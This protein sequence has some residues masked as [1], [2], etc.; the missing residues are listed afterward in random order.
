MWRY[1]A[2]RTGQTFSPAERF[3]TGIRNA[4][5]I[6]ADPTGL[7]I[8]ATQHGRDQLYE[9]WPDLYNQEQGANLP[10]EELLGLEEGADY[11]WPECYFDDT[12]NK[13]VLAPEYGGDGGKKVGVC[14]NKKPPIAVFPAHW[15]PNA[16]L[17]YYGDRFPAA[18]RGGGFIAFHGSWNR[19]PLPQGGYNVVFQPLA[20][21]KPSGAYVI[22]ADG[23]AGAVKEPGEAA[24]RPSGLALGSDGSLYI[25]DDQRGRIWKV[26][27]QGDRE[28]A[29]LAAAASPPAASAAT[30][31]EPPEGIH[32]GAGAE[33]T[34]ALPTPPGATPAQVALGDR[35]FHGQAGG[36]TCAGCHG[37]NAKGTPVGPDL[38]SGRRLW[39]DGSLPSI[40]KIITDGVAKPKE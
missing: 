17:L 36:G 23:F 14:A 9:N 29:G 12:Q 13:L 7:G 10:A 19:A 8:F 32:P 20:N 34:A 2:N 39:G 16:L 11:G 5:G 25:S 1:D 6:V 31:A 27:F 15:A 38:T 22:F 35:V 33:E 24:H 4:V 18:Y 21:G 28:T 26:S 40:T 37:S 30:Q 3:A